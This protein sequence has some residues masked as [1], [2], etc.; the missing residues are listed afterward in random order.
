[1]A[2]KKFSMSNEQKQKYAELFT[3]ALDSMEQAQYEKPWV[4]AFHGK[5]MN[6]KHKKAYQGMN[7]LLLPMLCAVR[8]WKVP[9]F[10]TFKQVQDMGLRLNIELGDDGM[11]KFKDNGTPEFEKA[12]PIFKKLTDVYKDGEK[13]TFDDYDELTEEEKKECR[14]YS[15]LRV[16]PEF[17][18]QQTNFA[19]VYPE[20]WKKLTEVPEH[21]YKE[22]EHD[23]VLER[24]ICGGEW[25][26]PIGFGGDRA[27]YSPGEDKIQLPE[28]AKFKGDVMFY[29]TALHEMAHS[30][31]PDVKRE[32][33]GHFGDEEYAKEEF[34][35]EIT[36]ASVCAMLGISKLLDKNHVAYVQNWK[37]A[38]RTDKDFIPTVL[39]HVQKA[40]NY[41]LRRYKDL[42]KSATAMPLAA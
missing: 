19:E 23:A 27:Y 8:G 7:E 33:N 22:G 5:P 14:W 6:Y 30:T 13:I 3:K 34:V 41:I 38:I 12:F 39:D 24:M 2:K 11:P 31:A 37:Q 18:I 4:S 40:T 9:L 21:E 36:A 25:R 32:Q 10:L 1:M 16:Y 15:A 17:N 29:Q 26:C 28:R 20:Q 35:A 42:D